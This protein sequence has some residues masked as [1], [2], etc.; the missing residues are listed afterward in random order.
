MWS[1]NR[2][3]LLFN[4][5]PLL[6]MLIIIIFAQYFELQSR[7]RDIGDRIQQIAVTT[8]DREVELARLKDQLEESVA[9]LQ[10]LE[11][12]LAARGVTIAE[13]RSERQNLESQLRDLQTTAE[14]E[15]E[16]AERD[17][18][19]VAAV[20]QDVLNLPIEAFNEALNRM[21]AEAQRRV[22]NELEDL[23]GTGP[24][25]VIRHLRT[26]SELK[27]YA[28]FWDVHVND[29]NTFSIRAGR[30]DFGPFPIESQE[31]VV[32]TI[33]REFLRSIGEPKSLVVI[34]FSQG[35]L[36]QRASWRKVENA[37]ETVAAAQREQYGQAK[38]FEIADLGAT[39]VR[40]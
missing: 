23:R 30:Q 15:R 5:T 16:R 39:P 32:Q 11:D 17:L 2:R 34:L 33:N 21:P 27:K 3:R 9:M 7:S 29:N 35:L 24:D 28:D 20:M 19:Q 26:V 22:R 10:R 13:L 36:A 31:Q 8:H 25:R 40:P 38:R 4:L 37:L 12:E 18:R 6:D 1:L 14:A